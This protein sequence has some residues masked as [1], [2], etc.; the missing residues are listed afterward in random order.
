MKNKLL[1]IKHYFKRLLF[2]KPL[3]N[4][5]FPHIYEHINSNQEQISTNLYNPIKDIIF[6][7]NKFLI[8]KSSKTNLKRL[9]YVRKVYIASI[10]AFSTLITQSLFTFNYPLFSAV[11]L[12]GMIVYYRSLNI[13]KPLHKNFI[14]EMY[15]LSDGKTVQVN[16][17]YD[18]CCFDI[19]EFRKFK[20]KDMVF[21]DM[22]FLHHYILNPVDIGRRMFVL[23]PEYYDQEL[24]PVIFSNSYVYVEE[25]NK[26][27]IIE[28]E[29]S[30]KKSDEDIN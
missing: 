2:T 24:L 18:S 5:P 4:N 8:F 7:N 11:Y 17:F 27:K 22:L 9:D 12:I 20:P 14:K 16:T 25:K 13:Y 28:I 3:L 19:K 26:G 15:L 29:L 23:K 1:H 10:I 21:F 6:V 30:P